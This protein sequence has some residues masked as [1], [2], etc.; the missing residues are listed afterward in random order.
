MSLLR[1]ECEVARGDG[2][3]PLSGGDVGI[4]IIICL[5]DK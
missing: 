4:L 1:A 2:H 3:V 5:P